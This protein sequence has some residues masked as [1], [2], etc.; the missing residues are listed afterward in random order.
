MYRLIFVMDAKDDGS[1]EIESEGVDA[2]EIECEIGCKRDW[3]QK[4]LDAKKI[5][6]KRGWMHKRLNSK[7]VKCE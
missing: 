6:C 4:R 1:G 7:K 3:M 5:G 2:G